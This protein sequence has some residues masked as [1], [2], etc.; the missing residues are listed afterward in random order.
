MNKAPGA[1]DQRQRARRIV[2]DIPALRR[3][4]GPDHRVSLPAAGLG[5]AVFLLVCDKPARPVVSPLELPVGIIALAVGG[6]FFLWDLM[7]KGR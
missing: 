4:V 5:G 6:P 3:I 2:R 1:Q 7:R